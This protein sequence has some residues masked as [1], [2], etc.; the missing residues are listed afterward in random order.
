MPWH[1]NRGSKEVVPMNCLLPIGW[2]ELLESG[3]EGSMEE[4]LSGCP[5]CR[6]IVDSLKSVASEGEF[7]NDWPSTLDLS[8]SPKWATSE[9]DEVRTGQIWLTRESFEFDTV[10]YSNIDRVF[11]LVLDEPVTEYDWQWVDVAP[12][13]TDTDSATSTDLLLSTE[14]TSLGVPFA[15]YLRYQTL[16]MT[17]QLDAC[18]GELTEAGSEVLAQ[19]KAGSFDTA[20]FG[21]QLESEADI[22]LTRTDFLRQTLEQLAAVYPAVAANAAEEVNTDPLEVGITPS[23]TLQSAFDALQKHIADVVELRR[24]R[25]PSFSTRLAAASKEDLDPLVVYFSGVKDDLELAGTLKLDSESAPPNLTFL[26]DTVRGFSA[27]AHVIVCVITRE[28]YPLASPVVEARPGASVVVASGEPV[29]PI[30]VETV[31]VK[32]R[33]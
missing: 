10:S 13:L 30:E 22:R 25:P 15:A 26:F 24:A 20:R 6:A 5:T 27:D 16:L 9:P 28:G 11:V 1:S 19:V 18:L 4:H 23:E 2:L 31:K 14:Q 3:D 17:N 12:L 32:L 7:S 33:P 8:S 21:A 29:L